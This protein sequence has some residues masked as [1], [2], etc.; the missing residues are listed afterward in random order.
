MIKAFTLSHTGPLF[1]GSM[2][3][4]GG[5]PA[6]LEADVWNRCVPDVKLSHLKRTNLWGAR[7]VCRLALPAD[8]R[9]EE[10]PGDASALRFCFSLPRGAYAT[11]L[12]RE[13]MKS[14]DATA[15]GEAD[16]AE[17]AASSAAG[18]A[19]NPLHAEAEREGSN[20]KRARTDGARA[21][22]EDAASPL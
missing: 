15:L 22:A 4:P 9:V 16:E 14:D 18:E 12:L 1:G 7:R 5:L 19:E 8:F 13:F 21:R 2:P 17:E 20:A 3:K 10:A 11:S 6:K